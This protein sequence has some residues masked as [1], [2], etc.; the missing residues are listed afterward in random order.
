MATKL[1]LRNGAG[2]LQVRSRVRCAG[3]VSNSLFLERGFPPVGASARPTCGTE[4]ESHRSAVWWR[5]PRRGTASMYGRLACHVQ[6]VPLPGLS[7]GPVATRMPDACPTL[8]VQ[9]LLA[10]AQGGD[11]RALEQFLVRIQGPVVNFLRRRLHEPGVERFVE[12]VVAEVLFRVFRHH[13]QCDARSDRA[14]MAWVL[15]IAHNEA[16]RLLER[17]PFRYSVLIGDLDPSRVDTRSKARGSVPPRQETYHAAQE[18]SRSSGLAALLEVLEQVDRG[19]KPELA[20]LLYL[21]LVEDRS[22]S[23]IGSVLGIAPSAAKLRFQR[24]Q[25]SLAKRVLQG[26]AELPAPKRSAATEFLKRLEK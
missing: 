16:L 21:R 20:R 2:G 12:D 22:W 25:R 13:E 18:P 17:H 4:N 11:E 7:G 23:E 14:V 10:S 24:A 3:A 15:T 5:A 1:A 19:I 6:G 8:S 9:E 26:V